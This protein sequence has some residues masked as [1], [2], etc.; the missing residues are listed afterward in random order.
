MRCGSTSNRIDGDRNS[1]FVFAG[2]VALAERQ[3]GADPK[4]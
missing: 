4:S 1:T 2:G 3:G